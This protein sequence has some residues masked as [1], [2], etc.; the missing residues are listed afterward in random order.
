M[1]FVQISDLHIGG[2]FKQDALNTI[3]EEVNNDLKPDAV[4]ISG[5]LTDEGLIFQF[6]QARTEINKFNCPNLIV[7]PGNH[8]YRH[9]GYLLFKKFFPSSKQIYEFDDDDVVVLTVGTAR[10]DRDEGEVGH[11]QNLWIEE[12]LSKYNVK[13]KIVAMHHH[14]I[15][16][17]DTGYANV[18]GILDAGDTLRAC[19]ESKVDLV[20]CGHKHRPWLWNLGSLKIAYAGTA[21]SWRY[22]GVF[23]DTYN[24]IEIKDGKIDVTIKLVGGKRM[25]LSDVVKKYE[26]EVRNKI[27][28]K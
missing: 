10:P 23:E 17:P 25:P 18:V 19:L 8:D 28:S 26:P 15:A 16:I 4:I 7:F 1:Q 6:Q 13:T 22:R 20:L 14:L 12:T 5:D 27:L 11:R 3:V 21:C 9:T 24:I 2:L